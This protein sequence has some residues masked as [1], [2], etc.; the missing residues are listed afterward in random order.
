MAEYITV[1]PPSHGEVLG[2][3]FRVE[4]T[5]GEGGMGVVFAATHQLSGKR[6][7]VKWLRPGLIDDAKAAQRM[8]REAQASARVEHPNIVDI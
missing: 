6:L 1:S 7:A 5:I 4:E 3:K 2:G 8:I